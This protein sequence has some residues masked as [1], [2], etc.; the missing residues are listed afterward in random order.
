M[1]LMQQMDQIQLYRF[2]EAHLIQQL[3]AEQEEIIME[4]YNQQHLEALEILEDQ[5]EEAEILVNLAALQHQDKDLAEEHL[6]PLG[7]AAAAVE[8]AQL[9]EMELAASV[10][11]VEMVY[12]LQLLELLH[13]TQAA[14][15][16]VQIVKVDLQ[17]SESEVW[18]EEIAQL[19][20]H[21]QVQ[22]ILEA[23]VEEQEIIHQEDLDQM[24]DLE[25]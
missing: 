17:A 3:V 18:V 4:E 20:I 11:Q 12:S 1:E 13:T 2:Q 22:Q 21:P 14:V 10:A 5:A 25:L 6:D 8:Q 9:V 15:V 23:V 7:M 19:E 24:E 16:D